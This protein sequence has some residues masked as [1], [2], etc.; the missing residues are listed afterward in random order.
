MKVPEQRLQVIQVQTPADGRFL[1]QVC[2]LL[3]SR[4]VKDP[5]HKIKLHLETLRHNLIDGCLTHKNRDSG[6]RV[7][8]K[9]EAMNAVQTLQK[10][11]SSKVTIDVNS[12]VAVLVKTDTFAQCGRIR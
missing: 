10:T 3:Y 4:I 2:K 8:I 6:L 1:V 5:S 9:P 12:I 7:R 11:T